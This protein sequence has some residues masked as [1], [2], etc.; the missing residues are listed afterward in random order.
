[1]GV[2]MGVEEEK[3]GERRRGNGRERERWWDWERRGEGGACGYICVICQDRLQVN[4]EGAL[5]RVSP[6]TSYHKH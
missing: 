1:M 5:N 3:G 2:E 4:P 6:P